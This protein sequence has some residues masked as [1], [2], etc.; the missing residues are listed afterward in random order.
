MINIKINYQKKIE[1]TY[2]KIFKAKDG[3]AYGIRLAYPNS[4][5]AVFIKEI[6]KD[7]YGWDYLYPIVYDIEL[8]NKSFQKESDLWFIAED[9]D[10]KEGVGIGLFERHDQFSIYM[11]KLCVKNKFHGLGLSSV[12]GSH[13]ISHLMMVP[14]SKSLLR[15]DCDV[16]ANIISSQ[17]FLEK[18][19]AIP[20]GFIANYNNYTDK[21]T[22]EILLG[23]PITAGE[24]GS[25]I[26]YANYLS[27]LWKKR[28]KNITLLDNDK[29]ITMYE[30]IRSINRQMKKDNIILKKDYKTNHESYRISKD[31]Y[32][33][34]LKIEGYLC[35][36]TLKQILNYYS[37]WNVIEWRVPANDLGIHS[38]NIALNNG[39]IVSG[40]DPGSF[41]LN[42]LEDTIL[43][44]KYPRGIDFSQFDYLNLTRRNKLIVDNIMPNLEEK[45]IKKINQTKKHEVEIQCWNN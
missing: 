14:E 29:I 34:T 40:Y 6:F 43:F 5:D 15:F 30:I 18:A 8:L 4:S 45:K 19:R 25:V 10:S 41:Y 32:K 12:L 2:F 31:F 26:M 38:Q 42:Q 37:N 7:I 24:L 22:N 3:N 35:K 17:K 44:C 33:A 1:N 21:R 13:I 36:N 23:I 16:R 20:Y 9:I 27:K 39:F 28:R 11:G